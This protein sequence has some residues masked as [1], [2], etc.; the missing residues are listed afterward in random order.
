MDTFC[1][2]VR[3]VLVLT[4]RT[5]DDHDLV[6]GTLFIAGAETPS[7]IC[8]STHLILFLDYKT[9]AINTE[10]VDVCFN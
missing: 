5:V 3:A 4:D 8:V 6:G 7:H 9:G 10:R 1:G 2:S